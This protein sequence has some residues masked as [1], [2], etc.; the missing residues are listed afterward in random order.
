MK[1]RAPSKD[2][3]KSKVREQLF[4]SFFG[5]SAATGYTTE[6]LEQLGT[7]PNLSALSAVKE[8]D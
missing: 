2:L 5:A 8:Q 4:P 7:K 6:Q 3:W 1:N